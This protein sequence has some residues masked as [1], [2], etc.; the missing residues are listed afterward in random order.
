[1]GPNGFPEKSISN[2]ATITLIPLFA[3]VLQTSTSS[4]E[5]NCA[6]SIPITSKSVLKSRISFGLMT[7]SAFI[8]IFP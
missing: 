3:K 7:V 2:P 5:K 1:M 6:S 4:E 8:L